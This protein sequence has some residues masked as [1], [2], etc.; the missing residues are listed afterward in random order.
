[1]ASGGN[2][3]DVFYIAIEW[4]QRLV[5]VGIAKPLDDYI[6]S[7]PEYVQNYDDL[8]P[9][10]QAALEIDGNTYGFGWDWNNV[11]IH[12]NT[13]M[14]EEV[15]LSMPGGDWGK[16]GYLRTMKALTRRVGQKQVC[17]TISAASS[18]TI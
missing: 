9:R 2:P 15:G 18:R 12:I 4:F 6:E 8:H 1:M 3:S 10:L 7:H 5:S 16:E 14:L 13:A 17:G 11:V